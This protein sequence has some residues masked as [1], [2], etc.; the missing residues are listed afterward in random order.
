MAGGDSVI[1]IGAGFVGLNVAHA[2]LERGL[3][4]TLIYPGAEAGRPSEGNAGWI[5][6]TDILPLASPKVWRHLPRW[7]A[8]PLGPLTIRPAYAPRIAPWMARF[9]A[10]SRPSRIEASIAAIRAIQAESLPAWRRRMEPLGLAHHLRER[11]NLTVFTHARHLDEARTMLERQR[12]FGIALEVLDRPALSRLEPALG[13]RVLGGVLYPEGCHVSDPRLLLADLHVTAIGRGVDEVTGRAVKVTATDTGAEVVTDRGETVSAPWLVIAAGAWSRPLSAQLGDRIPLDTERG[14]NAT[15]PPGR[16]GLTR[17]VT[18]EGHGFVTTPLDSGDR[19]GGA[20]EFAGLTAA[21]NY[22]R[23]STMLAKLRTLLPDALVPDQDARMWMGFR[24]SIPDSLPVIGPSRRAPRVLY[25]FGHGHYG[26][27]Q[28]AV[29]GEIIADLI[30]GA[31]PR[32]A[33]TPFRASRFAIA[34]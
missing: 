7:L 4:V 30:A 26:L 6:H 10:A 1:V 8:D 13:P 23:A 21:P 2:L 33:V 3:A 20:V 11:G 17:P 32:V 16:F 12:Q 25:A 27:T 34:G 19:I 5:A 9:I 18:F 31:E 28:S 15:F 24:P 22:K 29:T 14:Y